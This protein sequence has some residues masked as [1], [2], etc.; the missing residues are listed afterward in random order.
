MKFNPKSFLPKR[1][2]WPL[3]YKVAAITLVFLALCSTCS[4]CSECCG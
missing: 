3:V 2:D 4:G 1:I